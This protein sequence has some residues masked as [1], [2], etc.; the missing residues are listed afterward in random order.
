MGRPRKQ[1]LKQRPDGRYC[2][3]YQGHPFYGRT[4]DEAFAARDQ[5]IRDQQSGASAPRNITVS[6]YAAQWLPVAKASV[7][8][9]TY[10]EYARLL[11]KLISVVGD[12]PVRDVTPTQIKAV[13]SLHFLTAS[14]SYIKHARYIYNALFD[15]AVADGIRRSNPCRDRAARPHHGAQGSHRAITPEERRIIETTATGHRLWPVVMTMLYA[16]LRPMEA[17]AVNLTDSLDLASGFLR[18][19]EFIHMSGSNQYQITDAG[20]NKYAVRDIPLFSPLR[21]AL[22]GR[23]GMLVTAADGG[24]LTKTG[25]RKAWASYKSEIET[26]LNGCH[27]RWYLRTREHKAILQQAAQLR[28]EGRDAEADAVEA[29]IPPWREF[30]VTPYDLRHSFV[31]WCRDHGVELHTLVD[32]MGHADAT[33]IMRVYDDPTARSIAEAAR[34]ESMIISETSSKGVNPGVSSAPAPREAL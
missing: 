31:T 20:K 9:N 15:A 6:V 2:C 34:L 24:P 26:A 4:E 13:Y 19:R 3:K 7:R 14:D 12:H 8:A 11:D 27:K 28:V 16:G 10:N 1:H 21:S 23:I 29:Q 17:K 32:W 30:S 22:E 33:M 18:V 25:W 5:W